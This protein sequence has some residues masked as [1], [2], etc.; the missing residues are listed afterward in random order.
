MVLIWKAKDLF[1]YD[2]GYFFP[3]ATSPVGTY[4]PDTSTAPPDLQAG[5]RERHIPSTPHQPWA[6]IHRCFWTKHGHEV[7]NRSERYAGLSVQC[8]RAGAYPP[9]SLWSSMS[10][11]YLEIILSKE[12]QRSWNTHWG[13]SLHHTAQVLIWD[14]CGPIMTALV[15]P[16][17]MNWGVK[18]QRAQSLLE[19]EGT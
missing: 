15:C 18:N 6:L 12:D 13:P 5:K 14:C 1:S 2:S 19:P 8:Q 16:V 7:P 3:V 17:N 11:R 9:W 10:R 4:Q